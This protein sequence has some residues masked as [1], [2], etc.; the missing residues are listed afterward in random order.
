[1]SHNKVTLLVHCY[2]TFQFIRDYRSIFRRN[3][4]WLHG[5]LHHWGTRN[6]CGE[7]RG[8]DYS[9]RYR[10]GQHLNITKCEVVHEPGHVVSSE[11]LNSFTHILPQ[12]ASLLGAPL[13]TGTAASN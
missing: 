12:D 9:L 13:F 2:F 10:I 8:D 7:R 3:W 6:G 11:R 5:R 1:M 4:L